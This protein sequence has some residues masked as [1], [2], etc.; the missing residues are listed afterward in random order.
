MQ[1]ISLYPFWYF[2]IAGSI[3]MVALS[4]AS[5][6]LV[7]RLYRRDRENALNT[8]LLWL[9]SAIFVFCLFR[10]LGHLVKYVLLFSGHGT[11]WHR[12]A[13]VSGGLNSITFVVIFA[14]TIFFRDI[15]TIMNRMTRDRIKIEK[16]SSQLLELNRDIEAVVS[17]RTKA[18]MALQ[19][20]HG[21]RN[22]VMVIGGLLK[23]LCQDAEP[24]P[25][26]RKVRDAVLD[27]V[28]QLEHL[29]KGFENLQVQLDNHFSTIEL[30]S[31][32]HDA[33]EIVRHEA[34]QKKIDILFT[35]APNPLPLYGNQQY[36]KVA[37]L[38]L[39]RNAIEACGEKT[40]IRVTVDQT[41]SGARVCIEDNGPGIPGEVLE[42]IFEPFYSTKEGATGLG[43]PYVRQI[44]HEH[45]GDIRI[46]S[47]P[48]VG[49]RVE[50]TFPTHL[51][52]L[53]NGGPVPIPETA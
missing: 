30:N 5:M 49:T 31:L 42:H 52:T 14:V 10:A 33:L 39:L 3:A 20:A 25:R 48:G 17:D 27:Q 19:I 13:P 45:R 37:L 51:A 50:L 22:P 43:L 21:I 12:I 15:L 24:S 35:A 18:E 2:D 29:V 1:Q 16:T 46:R 53:Q 34:E 36:L 28:R 47:T 8:Y 41:E 7:F 40:R 11:L 32:V 38:H 23:H 9:I 4:A 44:I 6:R 26:D